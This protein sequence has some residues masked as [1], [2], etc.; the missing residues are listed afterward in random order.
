MSLL[1][2]VVLFSL[3]GGVVSLLGGVAMLV[4]SKKLK[5]K[6]GLL[7]AFAAGVLIAV[8]LLD[9]IPEAFEI[10]GGQ[11]LG[12]AML[13]GVLVLFLLEKTSVWFHHHHEPHGT[14]PEIVGVF[15]GDTLHNFIDGLAIGAAFLV[16]VPTGIATALA[17]GMHEFPQEIAD[18]SLYIRAGFSNRKTIFLNVVSSL[19][20]VFGAV[21]VY[22]SGNI[23]E[24]KIGYLLALT[25][26][27]F[28]YIA[29][30]DLL[31]ELHFEKNHEKEASREI[32][33]F[34]GG[35][36]VTYAMMGL[37]GA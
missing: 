26:G 29:L 22:L 4:W 34:L 31:P 3:L 35:I 5:V 12:L 14:D 2:Y 1:A 6:I 21:L 30:A 32:V 24:G 7:T 25:A 13:L 16:S 8:A 33:V 18:F 20:S 9:L 37:L 11:M 28:L 10:G 36:V 23:L 15:L 27:M 17:V 19:M